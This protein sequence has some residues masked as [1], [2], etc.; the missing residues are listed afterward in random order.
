MKKDDEK[1]HQGGSTDELGVFGFGRTKTGRTVSQGQSPFPFLHFLI[2]H[3]VAQPVSV[4]SILL[5]WAL[6]AMPDL[7]RQ[8][9]NSKSNR[10]P[11]NYSLVR[12][13]SLQEQ[14]SIC[15]CPNYYISLQS[16]SKN[17]N[18]KHEISITIEKMIASAEIY[19]DDR[20]RLIPNN[21]FTLRIHLPLFPE[22]QY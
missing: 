6:A 1:R 19:C 14:S 2:I 8:R 4:L 16:N 17:T 20:F 9:L 10:Q 22:R 11:R 18:T 3:T 13:I 5:F 12:S 21:D 7:S 15:Y